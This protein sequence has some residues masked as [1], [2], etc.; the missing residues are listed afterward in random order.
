MKVFLHLF[1]YG[2][3]TLQSITNM[4]GLP[5]STIQS[6]IQRLEEAGLVLTAQQGIYPVYTVLSL[7]QLKHFAS[8]RGQQRSDF[9][10]SLDAHREDF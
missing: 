1:Q 6:I 4:L 8:Y 10:Q 2:A 9:Q 5:R 7:D 3:Q